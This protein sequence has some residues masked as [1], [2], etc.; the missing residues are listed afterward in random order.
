[1]TSDLGLGLRPVLCEFREAGVLLAVCGAPHDRAY[2]RPT[3]AHTT[4]PW[5]MTVA[6][7]CSYAACALRL[8]R[9]W[10]RGAANS[11]PIVCA[12]NGA[13]FLPLV[14]LAR[15]IQQFDYF[16]TKRAWREGVG[17]HSP[18]PSSCSSAWTL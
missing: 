7:A 3:A 6:H 15:V 1:M 4:A 9:V 2:Q 13:L 16:R 8:F 17:T 12:R 14:T 18:S 5:Q 11:T 10:A